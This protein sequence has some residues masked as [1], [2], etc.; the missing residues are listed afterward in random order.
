MI[1]Q[2]RYFVL[3]DVDFT[4]ADLSHDDIV[5]EISH[6]EYSSRMVPWSS[7]GRRPFQPWKCV[8][9]HEVAFAPKGDHSANVSIWFDGRPIKLEQS[10][11]KRCRRLK[12]KKKAQVN[13]HIRPNG[14]GALISR[15]S[16]TD[17]PAGLPDI[18]PFVPMLPA[19]DSDEVQRLII[20][21]ME[22]RI[23]TILLSMRSPSNKKEY[24]EYLELRMNR[25]QKSF[26]GLSRFHRKWTWPKREGM[27]HITKSTMAPPAN[28]MPYIPLKDNKTSHCL[29]TWIGFVNNIGTR[30]TN[31]GQSPAIDNDYAKRLS[32]FRSFDDRPPCEGNEGL[33]H[34]ISAGNWWSAKID[35]H[36]NKDDTWKEIL[37]G[38]TEG[39][40]WEAALRL[41]K[42]RKDGPAYRM[43]NMPLSTIPFVQT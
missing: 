24:R 8:M 12:Q 28:I 31:S 9:A 7:N 35:A 41:H 27:N 36:S 4:C 6:D 3:L 2:A 42:S 43:H 5:K 13:N 21:I 34:I 40:K 37:Y 17:F 25:L 26:V 22:H 29:R 11:I 30:N 16:P 33:P 1:L 20:A 19:E 39:G 10:Q 18:E 32:V 15:T 14:T 38:K 23:E